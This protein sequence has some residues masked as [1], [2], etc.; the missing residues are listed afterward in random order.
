MMVVVLMLMDVVL[1]VMI[2][3]RLLPLI[4]RHFGL[5][6]ARPT[7]RVEPGLQLPLS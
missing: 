1:T 3:Y 6:P 4:E 7:S 2:S 5:C